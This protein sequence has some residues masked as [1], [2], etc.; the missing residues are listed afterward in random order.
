MAA[1]A[2]RLASSIPA[3]YQRKFDRSTLALRVQLKNGEAVK[4]TDCL[5]GLLESE[6][7]FHHPRVFQV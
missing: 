2:R 3:E 6:P 5:K 4:L 7:R 1:A